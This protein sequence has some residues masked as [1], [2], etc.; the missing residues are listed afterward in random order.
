MSVETP[1]TP[2][3]EPSYSP[4]RGDRVTV[5]WPGS[6]YEGSPGVVLAL[7]PARSETP[8]HAD[9]LIGDRCPI[10]AVEYLQL[11]EREAK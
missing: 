1:Q 10:I 5:E 6:R 8:T 11:E 7:H 2:Q 4:A 3:E 9:V